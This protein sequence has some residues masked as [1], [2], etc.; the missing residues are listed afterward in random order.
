MVFNSDN[1]KVRITNKTQ[2]V[3]TT[4]TWRAGR[5]AS[6]ITDLGDNIGREISDFEFCCQEIGVTP[7][8]P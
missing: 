2:S 7:D 8:Y 3:V 1:L 4:V 6:N 5:R